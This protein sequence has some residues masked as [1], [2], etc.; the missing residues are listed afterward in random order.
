MWT[1]VK[2][3]PD[4]FRRC[5]RPRMVHSPKP[6]PDMGPGETVNEGTESPRDPPTVQRYSRVQEAVNALFLQGLLGLSVK[7]AGFPGA[8]LG[9]P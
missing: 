2:G 8:N 6:H 5:L 4:Y 9:L 3:L 1:P 7:P